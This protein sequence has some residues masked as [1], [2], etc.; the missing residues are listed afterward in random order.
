MENETRLY[1]T[2]MFPELLISANLLFYVGDEWHM[3]HVCIALLK[4]SAD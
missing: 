4:K 2:M 3:L 1:A